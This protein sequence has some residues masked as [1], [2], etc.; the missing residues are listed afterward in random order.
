MVSF[1]T[2]KILYSVQIL[3]TIRFVIVCKK[4]NKTAEA[5]GGTQPTACPSA[6]P[7]CRRPRWRSAETERRGCCVSPGPWHGIHLSFKLR[8]LFCRFM[9][10]VFEIT[11]TEIFDSIDGVPTGVSCGLRTTERSEIR[12]LSGIKT[13]MFDTNCALVVLFYKPHPETGA[14]TGFTTKLVGIHL[15]WW[16]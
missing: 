6:I 12:T 2:Y 4:C 10:R 9:D 7:L 14:P 3:C 5:A 16:R 15:G 1:K 8:A 11:E 13:G